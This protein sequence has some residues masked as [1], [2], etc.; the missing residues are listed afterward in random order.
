MQ[1]RIATITLAA[2]SLFAGKA[3]ASLIFLETLPS[4]GNGIGAVNTSLTFQNSPTESGCVAYNG[5]AAVTG[6][7]ACPT[8]LGF[9]GGDEKTGS[10]QTNVFTAS[11]LNFD[12]THNFSNLVLIFN[13]NEGG[14]SDQPITINLLGLSL[15]SSTGTRLA[16]YTTTQSYTF[17]AFPG[18]GQAGFAFALD[19]AQAA[20]AN[21][22]LVSNPNLRIGTEANVSQS[23]AGPETI[24]LTTLAPGVVQ[25]LEATPEPLSLGLL[26][27][28]LVGLGLL[29]RRYL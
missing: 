4:T 18:I 17:N 7:G 22:L 9:T 29:K 28:S 2:V 12:A 1:H 11:D 27:V 25:Q 19:S 16:T 3:S 10:S 5:S 14:G 13:G 6:S 20:L 23:S 15:Y 8:G 21:A 26:G 24:Q